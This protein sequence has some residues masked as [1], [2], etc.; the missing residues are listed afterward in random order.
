[1]IAYSLV[2]VEA[3][4]SLFVTTDEGDEIPGQMMTALL[5]QAPLRRGMFLHLLRALVVKPGDVYVASITEEER[6]KLRYPARSRD[7]NLLDAAPEGVET[8]LLLSKMLRL[9]T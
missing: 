1:M 9:Q 7:L 2:P 5:R 3:S 6:A 4:W 8:F